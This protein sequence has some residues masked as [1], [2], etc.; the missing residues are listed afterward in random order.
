M[1]TNCAS[2]LINNAASDKIGPLSS[3]QKWGSGI[4]AGGPRGSEVGV[5]VR[6]LGAADHP[7]GRKNGLNCEWKSSAGCRRPASE[8]A[9]PAPR[10][11]RSKAPAHNIQGGKRPPLRG[12]PSRSAACPVAD[13][14]PPDRWRGGDRLAPAVKFRAYTPAPLWRVP[15]FLSQQHW[16]WDDPPACS[17]PRARSPR[18]AL[19]PN[20]SRPE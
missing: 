8:D 7:P 6:K 2:P 10:G 19:F 9:G 16:G 17:M 4:S 13:W 20:L 14:P 1:P 15:P 18:G 12:G 5:C 3:G 11:E